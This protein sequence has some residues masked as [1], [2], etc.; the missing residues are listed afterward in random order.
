[1]EA[2][3]KAYVNSNSN[4]RFVFIRDSDIGWVTGK[5]LEMANREYDKT[6]AKEMQNP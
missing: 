5:F 3:A 2:I 4:K 1:M 6:I